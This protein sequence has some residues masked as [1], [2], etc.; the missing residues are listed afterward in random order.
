MYTINIYIYMYIYIYIYLYISTH[1]HICIMFIY[2]HM[3]YA[4][5]FIYAHHLYDVSNQFSSYIQCIKHIHYHTYHDGSYVVVIGISQQLLRDSALWNWTLRRS[6]IK[7]QPLGMSKHSYY[8][9]SGN[10]YHSFGK[11][12]CTIDFPSKKQ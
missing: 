6:R 10:D 3:I 1:T 12:P 5:I 9:P 2:I 8:L 7:Q 4:Y 11:R